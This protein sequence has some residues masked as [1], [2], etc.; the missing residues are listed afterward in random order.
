MKKKSRVI[1]LIIIGIL[2]VAGTTVLVGIGKEKVKQNKR[3]EILA[4]YHKL[5][6]EK[7]E[8]EEILEGKFKDADEPM[9]GMSARHVRNVWGSPT[10]INERVSAY[11]TS[12][13]WVYRGYATKYVHFRDGKVT[14]IS[15]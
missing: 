14:S 8:R 6:E 2:I 3:E 13:Q 7:E 4:N 12:E 10:K 1:A 9:I 15:K 5:K 11:G